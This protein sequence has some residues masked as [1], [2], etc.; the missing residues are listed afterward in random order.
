[1]ARARYTDRHT[2]APQ[3]KRASSDISG[4]LGTLRTG[5][6]GQW[7][8]NITELAR[9]FT[10]A[11]FLAINTLATQASGSRL[12]IYE[13]TEDEDAPEGKRQLHHFDPICELW[14]D[15]NPQDTFIDLMYQ[16][17]QQLSLTGIALT[18]AVPSRD[19]KGDIGEL[20]NLPSSTA[21]P[22]PPSPDYPNGAY[23]VLPYPYGLFGAP[24]GQVSAGATIPAEQ[25]KRTRNQHPI[26]RYDGY[27][28]LSAI[29]LQVDTI[30]G[31]DKSRFNSQTQGCEQT[32]SLDLDGETIS[33]DNTDLARIRA[34]LTALYAGPQNAGKVLIPPPGAKF[35]KIST[36]P[37]EMGW[38]EG[39][40]QI[41]DFILACYGVPMAVAGLQ[42]NLSYATLYSSLR[43]FS[44]LSLGPVLLRVGAGW[45]KHIMRPTWGRE[46]GM[47]ILAPEF[48]DE[49]LE[50]LKWAN[51]IKCGAATLQERRRYRNFD[52]LDEPWVNERAIQ[53]QLP[54]PGGKDPGPK[55]DGQGEDPD[56]NNSRPKHL[57]DASWEKIDQRREALLTALEHGKTNGTLK[58]IRG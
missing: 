58:P 18:W 45:N 53:T 19:R 30:E 44:Y 20:Y 23:R 22:M 50:E 42:S 4:L 48:K 52:H 13:R 36:T 28:V 51:D 31:I 11:A 12:E 25:V 7:S 8:S 32:L 40:T 57:V 27:A 35:S 15:P 46:Y 10:G 56:S 38:T 17:V 55:E 41:L 2:E 37:A 47:S 54:P 1:M 49:A 6:P 9:H 29:A 33:P 14:E 5:A 43:A 21:W 39:W 3:V 34:Q 24:V 26:F 16:T